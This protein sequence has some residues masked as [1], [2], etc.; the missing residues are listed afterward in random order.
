LFLQ[1]SYFDFATSGPVIPPPGSVDA[2]GSLAGKLNSNSL[3]SSRS[4]SAFDFGSRFFGCSCLAILASVRPGR[5]SASLLLR[6]ISRHG[7]R[8]RL[9]LL[10]WCHCGLAAGAL[11]LF[12]SRSARLWLTVIEKRLRG[13]VEDFRAELPLA[14][15]RATS[16]FQPYGRMGRGRAYQ[17]GSACV[18]AFHSS[19]TTPGL[20][21]KLGKGGRLC[22][23]ARQSCAV[24]ATRGRREQLPKSASGNRKCIEPE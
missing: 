11:R 19:K 16:A 13:I 14:P 1:R 5:P 2:G 9:F 3:D 7:H 21:I 18:F 6:Q 20:G 23:R 22:R 24:P 12:V 4:C 15:Y 8:P 10:R 17:A